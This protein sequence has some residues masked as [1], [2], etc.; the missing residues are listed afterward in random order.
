MA[1][2]LHFHRTGDAED[3]TSFTDGTRWICRGQFAN[4]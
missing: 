2:T 4:G 3:I 1:M